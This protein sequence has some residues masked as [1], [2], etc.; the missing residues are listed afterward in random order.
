[1]INLKNIIRINL[2]PYR[3]NKLQSKISLIQIITE[4]DSVKINYLN[5]VKTISVKL[6]LETF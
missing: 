3:L 5:T 1:M 6:S 2:F 4:F